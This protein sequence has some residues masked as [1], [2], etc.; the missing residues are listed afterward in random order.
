MTAT[1]EIGGR[2]VGGNAPAFLIAE[3]AQAHDGSLGTAHAFVDAAADA[4]ADAVKFQTH[5]ADAESTRD[6]PFRVKFSQQDASRFDYWKRMEFTPEEWAGLKR[7]ADERGLAFMSSAFSLA[8]VELLRGLDVPAWKIAS[9]EVNSGALVDAMCADRRPVLLSTGMSGWDDID[10]AVLRIRRAQAP[11]AVLQC[12]SRYPT[13]LEAV[14]LNVI[15]AMSRR[16]DVPCGLSD[17][18]GQPWPA[19]AAIARGAALV[20]LHITLSE[21]MFGPDVP[22]SLTVEA[23]RSVAELRDAVHAM[24][25]H[26]VDKDAVARDLSDMRAMFGRSLAPARDLPAGTVISPEMLVAKKP[27]TGIPAGEAPALVGRT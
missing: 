3:V 18:S 27:A 4:G 15:E 16:Y 26:P 9:G 19:M 13:P 8:A 17:H 11:V 7:H 22:S 5:I 21:R 10:A 20:E 24:D 25:A 1:F 14:G 2:R 12:V 23:F 6:E